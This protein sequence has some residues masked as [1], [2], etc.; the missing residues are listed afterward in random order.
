[1]GLELCPE[2]IRFTFALFFVQII[3]A[4][5]LHQAPDSAVIPL[6]AFS[7]FTSEFRG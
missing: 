4:Q 3:F 2:F 1:M 5:E 7:N 6:S